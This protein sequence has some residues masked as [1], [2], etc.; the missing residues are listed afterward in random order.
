MQALNLRE[1]AA[2][3]VGSI[4]RG[5]T[6]V[7]DIDL[8][9][10][11]PPSTAD[12]DTLYRRVAECFQTKA[13]PQ[14][15][16]PA[17]FVPRFTPFGRVVSGHNP[18]FREINLEVWVKPT[19]DDALRRLAGHD[20]LVRIPAS[21]ARYTPDNRGW[22]EILRTGSAEFGEAVLQCW[23]WTCGTLGTNKPGSVNNQLV[24]SLGVPR[25]TPTEFHVFQLIGCVWVPPHLRTGPEAL[26]RAVEPFDPA[27]RRAAMQHLGIKDDDEVRDRFAGDKYAAATAAA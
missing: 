21:I 1:P 14:P 6:D 25:R 22:L 12:G 3:V 27:K 8:I 9:A 5:K 19:T 10:P 2:G 18:M 20:G 17:L 13:D 23:K 26:C 24:D 16:E 11:L 7:G 15:G 4:R